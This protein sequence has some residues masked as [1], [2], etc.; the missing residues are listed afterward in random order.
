MPRQVGSVFDLPQVAT[1]SG[2]PATGR[3]FLY[4]KSDGLLYRKTTTGEFPVDTT[5]GAAQPAYRGEWTTVDGQSIGTSVWGGRFGWQ[6]DDATQQ[7]V[8]ILD[9]RTAGV[10]PGEFQVINAGFYQINL[11]LAFSN[12]GTAL[13]QFRVVVNGTNEYQWSMSFAGAGQPTGSAGSF[14]IYL[15]A[16]SIIAP[17]GWQNTGANLAWN[18]DP[19]RN[20]LSIF[21]LG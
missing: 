14:S 10:N 2:T 8:G 1:P 20:R 7:P 13:R 11:A 12:D 6:P 9:S 15:P 21:S 4:F 16:N 17:Q 3:E 5:S 19:V 18:T